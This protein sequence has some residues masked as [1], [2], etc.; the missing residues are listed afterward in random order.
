MTA[1][2]VDLDELRNV[3]ASLAACQRALLDLGGEIHEEID[4]LHEHWLGRASDA[5]AASYG[6]WRDGCA[7]MVTALAALR[8]LGE[9]AEGNYR[10]A[11]A[12]NLAMWEQVR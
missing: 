11:V 9:A 4:D 12:T 7:E 6:S 2:D 5:H 8:G 1:F 10:A 3:I